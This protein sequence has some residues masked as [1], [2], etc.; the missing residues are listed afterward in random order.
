M[1]GFEANTGG[2]ESTSEALTTKISECS[3]GDSFNLLAGEGLD[4]DAFCLLD[5]GLTIVDMKSFDNLSS[6]VATFFFFFFFF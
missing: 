4:T 1:R 2:T 6:R 5:D 3:S